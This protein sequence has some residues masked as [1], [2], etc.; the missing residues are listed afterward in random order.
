VFP[1]LKAGTTCSNNAILKLLQQD[2][3]RPDV[4]VHGFRTSFRSWGQNETDHSREC[5]EFCLHHIEGGEAELA[6]KR[7]DMWEKRK[8]ALSAWENFCNTKTAPKLQLVA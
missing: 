1:G 2:L 5:L 7:G 8:A 3:K 4:T 6:Y